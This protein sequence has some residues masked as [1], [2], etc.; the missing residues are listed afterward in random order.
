MKLFN[1]IRFWISL[2]GG[3]FFLYLFRFTGHDRD[4]RPGSAALK[5]YPDFLKYV[6]KPKLTI[7]GCQCPS[8]SSPLPAGCGEH[9]QSSH[10][11]CG[12]DRSR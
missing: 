11:G 1:R 5:L 4:D 12:G 9:F 10:Q 7:V 3:L 6:A 8:R 2:W